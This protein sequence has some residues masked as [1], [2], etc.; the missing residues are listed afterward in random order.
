[1]SVRGEPSLM[2]ITKPHKTSPPA[3]YKQLT[4]EQESAIDLLI[5][6]KPDREVAEAVGVTR[7]TVWHWRHDHLVFIAELNRRR[8]ALWAEAL[9]RLR[10]LV[11]KAVDV[12]EQAV[13][14][15]DLKAAVEL[16]K[17]VKVHGEVSAPEGPTD[18]EMVLRQHA[19]AQARCE[20]GDEDP[21]LTMLRSLGTTHEA[22]IQ[23]R[24]E[25]IMV[26]LRRTFS[27]G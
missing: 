17:I 2:A 9:E 22:R 7:E 14:D 24:T 18:P 12:I 19:Q 27:D 21:T 8:K 13:G 6:G 26:E 15:G 3:A 1:M 16:L 11:G 20:L 10:V 25:E 4:P 23:A 5:L